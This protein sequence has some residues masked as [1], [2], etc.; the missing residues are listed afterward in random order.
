[1]K[2]NQLRKKIDC[3]DKIIIQ[4]LKT[5]M[6]LVLKMGKIKKKNNLPIL[7][8]SREKQVLDKTTKL[9]YCSEIKNIFKAIIK[10]SRNLQ[11][12]MK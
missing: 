8:K 4:S 3:V 11:K 9:K 1:M 6:E 2:I 5:R 10:E 7:N 12:E